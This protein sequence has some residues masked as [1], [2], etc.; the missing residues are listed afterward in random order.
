MGVVRRKQIL[1]IFRCSSVSNK[2]VL[3]PVL[4]ISQDIIG[5]TEGDEGLSRCSMVNKVR[6]PFSTSSEQGHPLAGAFVP[7]SLP[8]SSVSAVSSFR[9]QPFF[10]IP[11]ESNFASQV[12]PFLNSPGVELSRCVGVPFSEGVAF[13]L[14]AFNRNFKDCPFLRESLSSPRC[15]ASQVRFH[16]QS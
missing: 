1:A 11:L 15:F 5:E 9:C 13:P 4:E 10:S 3:S 12:V 6:L 16:P 7:K 2:G 8:V 14:E